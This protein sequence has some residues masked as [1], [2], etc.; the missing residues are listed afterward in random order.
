VKLIFEHKLANKELLFQT[1]D[2][3]LT[4]VFIACSRDNLELVKQFLYA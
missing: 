1:N 4:A 3:G 2:D